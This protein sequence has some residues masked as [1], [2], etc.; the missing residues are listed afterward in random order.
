MLA[1]ERGV[2]DAVETVGMIRSQA[3]RRGSAVLFIALLF[4]L[5]PR[6]G[7]A[8]AASARLI[9]TI[10]EVMAL[11]ASAAYIVFGM[12]VI[13]YLAAFWRF[14]ADATDRAVAQHAWSWVGRH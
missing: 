1:D 3:V 9:M 11:S 5:T 14:L 13:S 12:L 6:F 10:V 4:V 7:I 8:G 2:R